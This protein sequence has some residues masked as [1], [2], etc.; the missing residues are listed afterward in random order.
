M[1]LNVIFSPKFTK[2]SPSGCVGCQPRCVAIFFL[3]Q[4]EYLERSGLGAIGTNG[5]GGVREHGAGSYCKTGSG[6]ETGCA[7]GGSAGGAG[8]GGVAL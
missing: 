7:E 5:G 6:E 3:R 1:A 4:I 8:F 2:F